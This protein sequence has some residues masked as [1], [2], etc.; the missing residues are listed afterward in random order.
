MTLLYVSFSRYPGHGIV[1]SFRP[2]T[3]HVLDI[4]VSDERPVI[5]VDAKHRMLLLFVCGSQQILDATY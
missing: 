1:F 3:S 2:S 4:L 5:I